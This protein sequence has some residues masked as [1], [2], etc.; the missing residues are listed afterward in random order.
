LRGLCLIGHEIGE[1]GLIRFQDCVCESRD[2]RSGIGQHRPVVVFAQVGQF[3]SD[4]GR[5]NAAIRFLNLIEDNDAVRL[6]VERRQALDDLCLQ[7]E[8]GG[9]TVL[10]VSEDYSINLRAAQG[11]DR[12]SVLAGIVRRLDE[13]SVE[14][15]NYE[16]SRNLLDGRTSSLSMGFNTMI[17]DK[18][19]LRN[20]SSFVDSR[21]SGLYRRRLTNLG[22][23]IRPGVRADVSYEHREEALDADLRGSM[24]RDAF[25]GQMSFERGEGFN[26][27]SKFEYREDT[28][29][30]TQVLWETQGNAKLGR[31]WVLFGE[32]ATSE[33]RD[34]TGRDEISN[35]DKKQVGLAWRPEEGRWPDL[36]FK[37]L[38]LKDDRPRDLTSADGGYLKTKSDV[39]EYAAE[40]SLELPYNLQ[41]EEKI[42]VRD[43]DLSAINPA[44]TLE[45][46]QSQKAYLWINRLNYHINDR[47]GLGTE[48]RRLS[49]EGSDIN[50]DE[51]GTLFEVSYKLFDHLALGCGYNF[52]SFKSN[53]E[54]LHKKKA[55]GLYLRA[56]GTY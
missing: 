40:G 19:S 31:E 52:T 37:Y 43:E 7:V 48:W 32:Y 33:G 23:E 13:A 16:I 25:S 53:L 11:E 39:H 1:F 5:D 14:Y 56:Q 8:R 9:G 41:I 20:E 24:P 44:N 54:D 6:T 49:V 35:I 29:N 34:G 51:D 27:R 18:A 10:D 15:M 46:P 4:I 38:R 2:V 26:A 45:T 3:R 22:Y 47:W 55:E 17:S 21:R 12:N 42:V 36:L 50:R 30:D 28:G